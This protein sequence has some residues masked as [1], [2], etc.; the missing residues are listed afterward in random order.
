MS[1]Y[2]FCQPISVDRAS[3]GHL[4]EWCNKIA[5]QQ[6]TAIG[7][8]HLNQAGWFCEECGD[9]FAL[10]VTQ[11]MRRNQKAITIALEP[12]M[13]PMLQETLYASTNDESGRTTNALMKITMS[14]LAG[15][16]FCA[17][18]MIVLACVFNL[19]ILGALGFVVLFGCTAGILVGTSKRRH[20]S[21]VR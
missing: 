17:A 16:G 4:C 6:L 12:G 14:L 11:S 19:S 1:N 5:V 13:Q 18:G 7:G 20:T 15:V 2:A 3:E 9:E 21:G 8:V 10:A